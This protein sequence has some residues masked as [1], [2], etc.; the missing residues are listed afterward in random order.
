MSSIAGEQSRVAES[1]DAL[2]LDSYDPDDPDQG[3]KDTSVAYFDR[4]WIT[5]PSLFRY[6]Q[7]VDP[8]SLSR[9]WHWSPGL[10]QDIW[11]LVNVDLPVKQLLLLHFAIEVLLVFLA[12]C[13]LQIVCWLEATGGSRRGGGGI[14]HIPHVVVCTQHFP[15]P[16]ERRSHGRV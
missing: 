13:V 11:H 4:R 3:V 12:G 5:T 6:L 9:Q 16:G 15:Q 10:A 14:V 2:D 8:D 1:V 7:R